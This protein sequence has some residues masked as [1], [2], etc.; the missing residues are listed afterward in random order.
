MNAFERLL[1]D[2]RPPRLRSPWGDV[3][4]SERVGEGVV[5]V[6]TGSHG[7]LRLDADAQ[8]RLPREVRDCFLHGGGWAEEDC[9]A[10]IALT[11]LG[12]MKG[13]EGAKAALYIARH[14]DRYRPC[15]R[16]LQAAVGVTDEMRRVAKAIHQSRGVHLRLD[17]SIL[18]ALDD[19]ERRGYA[20]PDEEGAWVLLPA[21]EA[22][23]AERLP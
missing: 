9:E 14:F 15:L 4:F 18:T 17:D 3:Q 8:S 22:L 7:G 16:H 1:T 19:L 21:G 2:P 12:L 20:A 6:A 10:P 13:D 11:L 5:F 23:A